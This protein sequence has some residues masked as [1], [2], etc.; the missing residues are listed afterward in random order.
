MRKIVG[1]S[2]LAIG[3]LSGCTNPAKMEFVVP[4][5]ATDIDLSTTDYMTL[6]GICDKYGIDMVMRLPVV[7]SGT[8]VVSTTTP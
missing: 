3:L 4:D 6:K 1:F 5:G 7:S 2:I 8:V